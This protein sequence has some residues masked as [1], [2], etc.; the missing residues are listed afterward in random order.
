MADNKLE[1]ELT[2]KDSFSPKMK[3]ATSG[4]QRFQKSAKSASIALGIGAASLT[5]VLTFAFRAG[6]RMTNAMASVQTAVENVGANFNTARPEILGLVS[7]LEKLT[8]VMDTEILESFDDAVRQTGDFR[9]AMSL[10]PLILD[11]AADPLVSMGQATRNIVNAVEQARGELVEIFPELRDVG[12]AAARAALLVDRFGGAAEAVK[13]PLSNFTNLLNDLLIALGIDKN[14]QAISDAIGDLSINAEDAEGNLTPLGKALETLGDVLTIALPTVLLFG[15]AAGLVAIIGAM[16]LL[17]AVIALLVVA[18]A[19]GGILIFVFRE[20]ILRAFTDILDGVKSKGALIATAILAAF[21]PLIAVVAIVILFRK[22]IF[23]ILLTIRDFFQNIGGAIRDHFVGVWEEL[24]DDVLSIWVGLV[25]AWEVVARFFK[26]VWERVSGAFSSAWTNTW[27]GLKTAF[28]R[29]TD[30]FKNNW[31]R[32]LNTIA[33]VGRRIWRSIRDFAVTIWDGMKATFNTF[34]N[35]VIDGINVIIRALNRISFT[36]PD[37]VPGIGGR[38]FSINIEEVPHL[39]HGGIARRP[40]LAVI[41]E[42]GPEAVIPLGRGGGGLGMGGDITV[43]FRG[44]PLV[45]TD[46]FA[47][48]RFIQALMPEIRNALRS[49]AAF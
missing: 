18:L 25:R 26:A 17:T 38:G 28:K 23:G 1:T 22:Q 46:D 45:L 29:V 2:L 16:S 24:R 34:V 9:R 31:E 11:R 48:R 43:E 4:L 3:R 44:G 30:F 47:V 42:E 7:D 6:D 27:N 35:A 40:T 49:Q 33:G 12:S 13:S 10:L 8:G 21:L 20:Q 32:S 37:W 39:K 36:L 14:I 41:G 19:A 15:I 5:A